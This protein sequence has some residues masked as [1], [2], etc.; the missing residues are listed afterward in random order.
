VELGNEQPEPA[1][2]DK[3]KDV[4]KDIMQHIEQ[5]SDMELSRI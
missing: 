4:E 5:N 3:Y 1:K 2:V